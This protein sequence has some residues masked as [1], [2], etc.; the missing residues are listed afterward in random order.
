MR[1]SK[2]KF[3]DFLNVALPV[4]RGLSWS[5]NIR[6]LKNVCRRAAVLMLQEGD[7]SAWR[8]WFPDLL[9]ATVNPGEG[10]P[11]METFSSK[12][13]NMNTLALAYSRASKAE[14]ATV[15]RKALELT[16]GEVQKVAEGLGISRSTVWR[17]G[18]A[19]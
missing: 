11:A 19:A 12:L 1:V 13:S 7:V 15:V 16:G 14:R 8:N 2:A 18:R 6:Q 5:G 17:L 4:L 10:V 3:D 9:G